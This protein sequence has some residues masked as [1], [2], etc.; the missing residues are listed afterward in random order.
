MDEML[1]RLKEEVPSLMGT[2]TCDLFLYW[3][4]HEDGVEQHQL[5]DANEGK[6]EKKKREKKRGE[7][8]RN[9]IAAKALLAKKTSAAAK[10]SAAEKKK[11]TI[12]K[13]SSSS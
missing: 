6:G 7:E 12:S 1:K 8:K 9:I 2:V 4:V 10:K 11:H 3:I 5:E 13:A